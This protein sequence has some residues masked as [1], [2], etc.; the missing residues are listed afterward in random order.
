MTTPAEGFAQ[1]LA[2]LKDD[3]V[4]QGRRVQ[5]LIEASFDAVLTRDTAAAAK[6]LPMDEA[7]DRV[8]VAIEKASVQLLQDATRE[9]SELPLDQLRMVLTIVKINNE[10]ER[11]ADAGVTVAELAEA[12]KR[13]GVPLPDTLRVL[14]NSVIG[15][16]RDVDLA[17]SRVDPQMAKLVLASEDAVEEF[18]K[19]VLRDAQMQV[20]KGTMSVDA[21]FLMQE[22]ATNCEIMAGHCTNIAEQVL[23]VAT[24]AIVRHTAGHWQQ[25]ELP[26]T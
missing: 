23:Y 10:L 8:D 19:A 3:L 5:S 11:I 7:V 1:R 25:Y 14:A 13:S 22:I 16:L 4:A 15:I 21:A 20:A 18:K 9:G 12:L 17:F 26:K 24:G 2:R 6:V